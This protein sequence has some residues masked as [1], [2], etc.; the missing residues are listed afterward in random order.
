VNFPREWGAAVLLQ[1]LNVPAGTE[2]ED[3]V[4]AMGRAIVPGHPSRVARI[5][6]GES[7]GSSALN[8]PGT[9]GIVG[10]HSTTMTCPFCNAPNPDTD[11]FCGNC[12]APLDAASEKL[13]KQIA[14]VVNQEFKD[15]D[16]VA[17]SLGLQV[18]N[19]AEERIWQWTKVLGYAATILGLAVTVFLAG[20]AIYGITS[21]KDARTRIDE[22]SRSAILKLNQASQQSTL[23]VKKTA[24]QSE[25]II[26][27]VGLDTISTMQK[28]VEFVSNEARAGRLELD[29][30]KK[31]IASLTAGLKD[32]TADLEVARGRLKAI[33]EAR[34]QHPNTPIGQFDKRLFIDTPLSGPKIYPYGL[35]D[36][37]PGVKTI[38]TRLAELGCYKGQPSGTF[39]Q[40]TADAVIA[41]VKVNASLRP[42]P[43]DHPPSNG[44]MPSPTIPHAVPGQVD[45]HRWT[46]LFAQ[47]AAKCPE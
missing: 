27:Q 21:A 8:G 44:E 15:Q 18:A 3:H 31:E 32:A 35:G 30:D 4:D 5:A 36:T 20:L 41:F 19:R 34:K 6:G 46:Q 43:S 13:R 39:D 24:K 1:K 38:Q 12:A 10:S 45:Y 29:K 17:A 2:K 16:M 11:Y 28:Q 37:R 22:A 47:G 42:S 9:T 23:E 25:Q 33:N 7:T 40:Q 14:S 26:T